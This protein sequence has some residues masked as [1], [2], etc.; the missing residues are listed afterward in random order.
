MMFPETHEPG[1]S[2]INSSTDTAHKLGFANKVSEK[3]NVKPE[4]IG[5]K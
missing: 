2:V 4:I 1:V 3:I 5:R